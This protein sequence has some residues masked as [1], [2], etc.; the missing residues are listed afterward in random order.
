[1][2]SAANLSEIR[3]R[4]IHQFLFRGGGSIHEMLDYV[5]TKCHD[6]EIRTIKKR[7]LDEHLSDLRKGNFTR[8]ETT[9]QPDANGDLFPTNFDK[10]KYTYKKGFPSPSFG[11]LDEE[12]R[13]SLPFLLG[14]L[15]PYANIP[16]V[17]RILEDIKQRF[18]L[19]QLEINSAKAVVVHKP[20]I[21]NEKKVVELAIK[22]LEHIKRQECIEFDYLRVDSLN[23]MSESKV[24]QVVPLQIRLYENMYYLTAATM[25]DPIKLANY[26]I[27]KI[28]R[29]KV[30][31]ICSLDTD[32]V[33]H[34]DYKFQKRKFNL[35]KRFENSLGIW[36]HDET[37]PLETVKIRFWGW[38]ASYV[39][40]LPLHHS[41]NISD[42]DLLTNS[43]VA[44]IKIQ[45]EPRI[46]GKETALARSK[47]LA[48]LL[49]R[50]TGFYELLE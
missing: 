50:F 49:G 6:A 36:L 3:I 35:S 8:A 18:E 30:D 10:E 47:E 48:F 16:S 34:F 22:I 15:N 29:L 2:K 13:I 26:R 44:E 24:R 1:M 20:S 7:M 12:E 19:D 37:D 25:E 41:Q 39:K 28:E 40:S 9:H 45:L 32:Q 46:I 17:A 27:D 11:D 21:A 42:I 33:V 23:T 43:L 31:V 5:N 14:I 4:F 38:A